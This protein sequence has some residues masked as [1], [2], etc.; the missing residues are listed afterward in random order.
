MLC[1]LLEI[2]LFLVGAKRSQSKTMRWAC[3]AS[4]WKS[5]WFLV[6]LA[7]VLVGKYP[8]ISNNR[9]LEGRPARIAGA[10]LMIPFP[11]VVLIGF[12]SADVRGIRGEVFDDRVFHTTFSF[13]LLEAAIFLGFLGL[14]LAI[15][16]AASNPPAPG[17]ENPDEN[18][19][20]DS[21]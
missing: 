10:V 2:G 5:A 9:P 15:S 1:F 8:L 17:R 6:G 18:A 11:L 21:Q 19:I 14:S 13:G 4:S 16:G 3:C 12:I 20:Q 7:V